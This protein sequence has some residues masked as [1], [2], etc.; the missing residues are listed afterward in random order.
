MFYRI[1]WKLYFKSKWR[2]LFGRGEGIM[3]EEGLKVKVVN[4][5]CEEREDYN[6]LLKFTFQGEFLIERILNEDLVGLS[7]GYCYHKKDLEVI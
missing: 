7:N 4:R 2:R 1:W 3:L 6:Q 5:T